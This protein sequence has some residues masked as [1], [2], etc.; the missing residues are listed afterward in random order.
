MSGVLGLCV[1]AP[2]ACGLLALLLPARHATH[3]RWSA[4]LGSLVVLVLGLVALVDFATDLGAQFRFVAST[5]WS[6]TLGASWTVGVDG[7]GAA[8]LALTGLIAGIATLCAWH[9]ARHPRAYH[10]LVMTLLAATSGVFVSLD[11]LAFFVCWE[12]MLVPMLALIG[13]WGG[14]Q[15]RY[16]ALKF[17]VFTLAGSAAMLVMIV[18]L[19]ATT[20]AGGREVAVDATTL[21]AHST[22][23]GRT[24]FGLGVITDATSARVQVPRGFD[25]R[26]LALQWRAFERIDFLGVSLAAFGFVAML[27]AC[28]VKLPAAPL[29]T[30]LPHA[31][32][33]APTAVSVLLAGVLLKLGVYGLYR[34]AWPLFPAQAIAWGPTLGVV[35]VI[36]ILWA[37]WVALGQTD[38]KRLVAY[39]SVSHMGACLLGLASLTVGGATGGMVVAVTHGLSSSLLFLLVGVLYER[40]HHRRIDGFG[41]LS[42]AMPRFAGLFLFAALA[43]ASLPALAGFVGE[44]LVLMGAFSGDDPFPL[45]GGIA[46]LSVILGAAYLLSATRRVVFGPLRHAE[47]AAFADCDRRELA[48]MLPLVALIVFVGIWPKPLVDALRPSCE[49]MLHAVR[50]ATP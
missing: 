15:R 3:A 20:P 4:A 49:A 12:L 34:I 45:L 27:L 6:E 2:L 50:S 9:E 30:W 21:A 29:H 42:A 7:I 26:H 44:F 5:P 22:D 46:A 25:V 8:M 36:G 47:H 17:F 39:S 23:G 31:H 1:L 43:S 14:E 19:W 10:A 33:Q 24:L 32:V 48:T 18:A 16:A 41:G 38:L 37:A 28:L 40:A 11:L 13:I 35:A